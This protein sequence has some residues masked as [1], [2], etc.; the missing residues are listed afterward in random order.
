MTVYNVEELLKKLN[1]TDEAVQQINNIRASEPSRKVRS[2]GKNVT[3][4][5]PSRKMGVTI[6]FESHKLE[7]AAIYEKEHDPN[8]LEYYDQPPSFPI[9]YKNSKGSN[10]KNIGHRYTADFFVIEND[11]IGWEEWKTD[12]DL[13]KLSQKYPTRYCV[14]EK[15]NWRCPPAEEYAK[16]LGLMFRVK[17]SKEID[18]T[19]QRN[20]LFLE[21]YLLDEKPYVSEEAVIA[22]K[23]LLNDKP[24]ITLD[25]LLSNQTTFLA[26]DI[27]TLIALEEIYVDLKKCSI[28]DFRNTPLFLN[29]KTYKAYQNMQTAC[30]PLLLE[31]TLLEISVGAKVYWDVKLWTIINI[32]ENVISLL[33]EVDELSE[34]PKFIFEDLIKKGSIKGLKEITKSR[35][36]QE[37]LK[38][39]KGASEK[40]L[41]VAN[42][43]YLI[44]QG[45]LNG[46]KYDDYDTS[47][48]TIRDWI[49][50]YKDAEKIYGNG[51][52]GLISRRSKQGNRTE[53]FPKEVLDLMNKY[54]EEKYEMIIQK[55]RWTVYNALKKE[56]ELKGYQAPCFKT[57]CNKVKARP[58]HLQ[59]KKR[60]GSKASYDTQPFYYELRMTTPRHGD[61]PFEIC[62]IDHTEL[63]IE[64]ICSQTE[65]NLGKPWI[66]FLVDAFS[67]RILAFYL[68][69]DPPSYRSCMMVL[70]ECVRR[71]NRLPKIIIVDGGKEF[72]SVL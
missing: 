47:D 56:C 29:E 4:F 48:R 54:I 19:Y 28:V 43:K 52:V 30:I 58:I 38:I 31:P 40:E 32:T 63:D 51:Y 50:K 26:D 67:R 35:D 16:Q 33:S 8:V 69:F 1:L 6:Q 59:T 18:W 64:L 12:E 65:E 9:K 34:I 62:H 24:F 66:T 61:R 57:F 7:L 36:E 37:V 2:N 15:G 44:V 5:Y 10:K 53:R 3:G 11:W 55:N 49:K 13:L 72:H 27:Y 46:G 45:M 68:T 21:D 41:E 14:D 71:H 20:L 17:S 42:R 70:R 22:I 25:E 23:K 39:I 60:K